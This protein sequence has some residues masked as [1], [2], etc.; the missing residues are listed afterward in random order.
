MHSQLMGPFVEGPA[1]EWDKEF[2]PD[3]WFF[4]RARWEED[5][6]GLREEEEKITMNQGMVGCICLDQWGN[7]ALQRGVARPAGV[8]MKH[9]AFGAWLLMS[10]RRWQ[11]CS[12]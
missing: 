1:R 8:D 3:E 4:T 10:V 12:V 7:L 5:L 6:R 11:I 9:P 2:K